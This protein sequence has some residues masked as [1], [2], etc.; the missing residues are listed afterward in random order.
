MNPF[1]RTTG[2]CKQKPGDGTAQQWLL[3]DRDRRR[4]G[5]QKDPRKLWEVMKAL[6]SR[7]S[8]FPG[9]DTYQSLHLNMCG[10]CS[11]TILQVE[12]MKMEIQNYFMYYLVLKNALVSLGFSLYLKAMKWHFITC[13]E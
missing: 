3:G 2:Q 5:L 11:S 13:T 8:H 12:R 7:G 10:S 1:I 4:Q 9:V 6:A